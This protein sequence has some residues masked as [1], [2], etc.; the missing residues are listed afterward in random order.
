MLPWS[1]GRTCHKLRQRRRGGRSR[2]G[3]RRHFWTLPCGTEKAAGSWGEEGRLKKH[4][5]GASR[6]HRVA[7]CQNESKRVIKGSKIDNKLI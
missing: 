4:D 3:K 2:G 5:V 1:H 7:G 6:D